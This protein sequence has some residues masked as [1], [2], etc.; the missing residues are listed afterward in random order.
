MIEMECNLWIEPAD[1]RCIPTIGATA[2]DGTAMM[3]FGVAREAASKFSGIA[4]DL[5]HLIKSRGNHVHELRP[6]L[7]SFPIQQYA[8][9]GPSLQIIERSA[10]QLMAIVGDKKTL[11]PRPGCEAGQLDWEAVKGVLSFLP[12]NIVVVRHV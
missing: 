9:S 5:G 8:W 10:R 6:G 11:L 3:E 4:T 7:L 2:P 1:Y 12:D